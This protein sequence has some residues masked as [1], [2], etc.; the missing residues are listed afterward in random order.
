MRQL[1]YGADE[2]PPNHTENEEDAWK[3]VAQGVSALILNGST[4]FRTS[5]SPLLSDTHTKKRAH[6]Q[7]SELIL[8]ETLRRRPPLELQPLVHPPRLA[9]QAVLQYLYGHQKRDISSY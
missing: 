6:P 5:K 8:K 2:S 7:S 9:P 4:T 3:F 1:I